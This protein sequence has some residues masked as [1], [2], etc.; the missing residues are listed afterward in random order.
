MDSLPEATFFV[1]GTAA[2]ILI[3]RQSLAH[4]RSHGFPRFFAWECILALLVLNAR[5]WFRE[6]LAWHQLISWA[7]LVLSLVLVIAGVHQLRQAGRQQDTRRDPSLLGME[8]TTRLVTNGVYRYIRHPMYSSLL[9]LAWGIFFKSPGWMDGTLALVCTIFLSLTA[10]IEERENI[11]YFGEEY[12]A[13]MQ[14]SKRFTP[15][16]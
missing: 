13:Y 14:R 3:S 4:P 6:P 1:L 10:R 12:A 2:L 15:F 5:T 16:I 7:L 9:F 8:K 11:A